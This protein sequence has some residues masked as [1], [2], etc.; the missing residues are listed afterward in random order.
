ME[1][2]YLLINLGAI[3]IPFIFSFHPR[4]R[5]DRHWRETCIAIASVGLLFILWDA[6]FTSMGVWWFNDRY[7]MGVDLL[8]L[9]LEEWLFFV[10]IPYACMFTYHC[11]GV[12]LPA[13]WLDRSPVLV[14]TLLSGALLVVA[15]LHLDQWY[16]AVTF[17][18]L[19]IAI[20]MHQWV[21]RA[22]WL[23]QFYVSYLVLLIPFFIVNG[24]LT[25]TA[26]DEPVVLYNDAENLGI[27]L[28]TI[29]VEDVFYGML[30]I[31][32]NVSVLERLRSRRRSAPVNV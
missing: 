7:V 28:L 17:I 9:P 27:R 12:L 3:S 6:W 1:T 21:L 4:L 29:P 19:A 22:T 16:T 5:F 10:C 18:A 2:T 25:G 15:L 14:S 31:L 8:G 32:L 24:L 13:A 20:G 26:L 30:L 23:F 11:F